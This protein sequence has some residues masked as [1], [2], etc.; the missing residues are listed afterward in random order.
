MESPALEP[1]FFVWCTLARGRQSVDWPAFRYPGDFPLRLKSVCIVADSSATQLFWACRTGNWFS[2]A[3]D[4]SVAAESPISPQ[5]HR[6]S[7]DF[8]WR[9]DVRILAVGWGM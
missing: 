6:V 4:G 8:P 5:W 7:D 1:G 3:A 9:S 2:P